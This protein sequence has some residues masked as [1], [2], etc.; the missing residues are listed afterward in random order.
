MTYLENFTF[1]TRAID[2]KTLAKETEVYAGQ[3]ATSTANTSATDTTALAIDMSK[4]DGNLK[5]RYTIR[6][7]QVE[8]F[9]GTALTAVTFT[10]Y[11]LKSASAANTAAYTKVAFTVPVAELKKSVNTPIEFGLP[12]FGGYSFIRLGV[13]HDSTAA[14]T[15]GAVIVAVE[16][17]RL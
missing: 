2:L 3:Y 6:L 1:G 14:L 5:N 12:S 16:P 7:N 10:F 8:A 4:L 9:A 13:Q 11:Y 17:T 15:S